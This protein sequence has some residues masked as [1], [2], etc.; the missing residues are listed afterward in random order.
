MVSK[1]LLS[2]MISQVGIRRHQEF[3]EVAMVAAV[4]AVVLISIWISQKMGYIMVSSQK[5][6]FHQFS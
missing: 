3:H 1:Q 4:V 2:G 6:N 5:N